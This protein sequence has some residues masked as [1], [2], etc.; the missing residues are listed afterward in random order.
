[1]LFF[2]FSARSAGVGAFILFL[3]FFRL[4]ADVVGK[5]SV[6]QQAELPHKAPARGH[7]RVFIPTASE[8]NTSPAAA[9]GHMVHGLHAR[10]RRSPAS[11][12]PLFNKHRRL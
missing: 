5:R 6:L 7:L 12:L 1:M 11:A 3:F 9:P 10:A 8:R 4:P 2:L